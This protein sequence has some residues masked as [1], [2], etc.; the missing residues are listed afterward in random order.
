MNLETGDIVVYGSG[1]HSY[2]QTA[3]FSAT[4]IVY[5]VNACSNAL[6][7]PQQTCTVADTACDSH[8]CI[9]VCALA[10]G[11]K[12]RLNILPPEEEPGPSFSALHSL[13]L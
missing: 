13:H 1:D 6:A 11:R 10:G 12:A 5:V 7:N 2:G 9:K 3:L 4:A 8:A